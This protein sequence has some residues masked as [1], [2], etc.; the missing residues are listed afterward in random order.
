M[1]DKIENVLAQLVMGLAQKLQADPEAA[2]AFSADP[3]KFL[4]ESGQIDEAQLE[5]V[6]GDAGSLVEKLAANAKRS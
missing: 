2:K 3:V 5:N 6:A 1:T 4:K